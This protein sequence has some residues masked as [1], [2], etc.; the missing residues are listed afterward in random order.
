M[1]SHKANTIFK[2]AILAYHLHDAIDQPIDNPYASHTID[3][4]LYLKCWIDTVQWH[5]EDVVR[6]PKISAEKGLYWK[7]RIDASN[8]ERTDT[9]EY[10]DA[11]YFNLYKDVPA[12]PDAKI[13]TESLAW[14]LD[15]LS[16][17][18]LKIYHMKLEANRAEAT[19]QHRKDCQLKL[20]ILEHQQQ[21][22]SQSIDELMDDIQKG[23]K[24]IKVY[25]QMKMYND[26]DLNPVLY[27][28]K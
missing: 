26:P 27:D 14:A 19:E 5:M 9:V 6:D 28:T 24:R 12:K 25:K 10:I 13:N 2:E 21:D 17:L 8:Q 22:L 4:L 15:R 7:R 1:I 23:E 11:Y 16:I 3:H 20:Q 18:A